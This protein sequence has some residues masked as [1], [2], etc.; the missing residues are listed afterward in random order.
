MSRAEV[1]AG[2]LKWI[3]I[4]KPKKED[5]VFLQELHPFDP[6]VMDY[7]STPTLHPSLEEFGD[8]VYFILH[9]P[10]I[11]QTQRHNK[12]AEVDFLMTKSVLI[13]ITYERYE[14][15]EK[16]FASCEEDQALRSRYFRSHSGYI[17]YLILERLYQQMINDRDHIEKSIDALERDLFSSE[18][19]ML[20]ERI[21]EVGRDILDFRRVFKTQSSVLALLPNAL[22]RM[23]GGDSIPKFSN[24]IVTQA[25]IEQLLDSHK[26]TIDT[27]LA[28]H[29][30]LADSRTSRILKVLTLFS[31]IILPLSLVAGIWGM[32]QR[33][34]PLRDGPNDFW[35]VIAI[36]LTIAMALALIF[37]RA[38]WM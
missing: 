31:A 34:L 28:T 27:L 38:K 9:F 4:D 33:F 15:L 13:T 8:N 1:S 5:F 19:E 21:S 14:R 22:E 20:V 36:M 3:H 37:R 16:L 24:V 32:N 18:D 12:T 17:L 2:N 7:V 29:R 25:R 23:L 10:V 30:T 11:Y 35:V 26:E 6:I